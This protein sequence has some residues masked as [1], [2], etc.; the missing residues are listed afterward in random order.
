MDFMAVVASAVCTS[1]ESVRCV[2]VVD[3]ATRRLPLQRKVGAGLTREAFA[4]QQKTGRFGHVGMRESV[5]LIGRGLGLALDSITQ[6]LAPVLADDVHTTPFL[7][8]QR[9]QVAGIHNIGVGRRGDDVLV[10]LE[11]S[12]YVGAPQPRD[13]VILVGTPDVHLRF[14]GGIPG[15][16]ATAAILVN[17]LPQVVAAAPGLKTVLDLPPPRLVR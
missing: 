13:E 11:L 1:V 16:A 14:Q 3:A 7:T 15:D 5:A 12:M 17:S 4:E 9:G 10:T 2:R 8:V 6:T